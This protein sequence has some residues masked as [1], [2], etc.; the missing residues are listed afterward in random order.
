MPAQNNAASSRPYSVE[1]RACPAHVRGAVCSIDTKATLGVAPQCVQCIICGAL[2]HLRHHCSVPHG[3]RAHPP[4]RKVA[5]RSDGGGSTRSC[6]HT[7]PTSR[8]APTL[9]SGTWT[10]LG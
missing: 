9:D 3:P 6:S 8:L 2:M 10:T 5:N 1:P 4:S 7:R